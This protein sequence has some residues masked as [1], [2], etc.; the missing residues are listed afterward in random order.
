MCV[1][2]AAASFAGEEAFC[3]AGIKGRNIQAQPKKQ[4]LRLAVMLVT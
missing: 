3:S 1:P 2:A 4:M